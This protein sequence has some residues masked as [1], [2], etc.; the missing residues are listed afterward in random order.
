MR[1]D[2]LRSISKA[3]KSESGTRA[4]LLKD[5]VFQHFNFLPHTM[6]EAIHQ[7]FVQKY[8]ENPERA[9]AWLSTVGTIFLQ[10]Y[11]GSP[12]S[13][14]EWKELRDII[15]AGAGDMDMDLLSYAMSLVVEYRAL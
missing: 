4:A 10:D 5:C 6:Q 1:S 14:A 11:D 15:S 8:G 7:A 3:E 13:D 2:I 12:L 9:S